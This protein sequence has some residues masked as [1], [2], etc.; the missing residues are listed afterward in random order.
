MKKTKKSKGLDKPSFRLYGELKK[1]IDIQVEDKVIPQVYR[2][3][4]NKEWGF[5]YDFIKDNK[6]FRTGEPLWPNE[7]MKYK[8]NDM[9]KLGS[10]VYLRWK[11]EVAQT[12]ELYIGHG[13]YRMRDSQGIRTEA[14]IYAMLGYE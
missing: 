6:K 1:P 3:F 2:I 14:H 4:G 7:L 13:Y 5:V 11:K 8:R 9:P 12:I 10:Q